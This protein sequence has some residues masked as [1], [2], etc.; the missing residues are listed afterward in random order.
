MKTKRKTTKKVG[1]T[2]SVS[3]VKT[4]PKK[5]PTKTNC[6]PSFKI[7]SAGHLLRVEGD[8]HAGSVLSREGKIQ[9]AKRKKKGCLNG[10]K[11]T[12]KLTEKQKRNLP[13]NL[14]KAI[15]NYHRKQGKKIA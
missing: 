9:K 8:S 13:K 12:F 10:T 14:Q 1:K 3:K 15:L 5:K 6:R 4:S 11:G 7:S 2:K